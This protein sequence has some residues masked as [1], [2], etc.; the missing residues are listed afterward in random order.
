M[1]KY[2]IILLVLCST[3]LIVISCKSRCTRGEEKALNM[4]KDTKLVGVWRQLD[5]FPGQDEYMLLQADGIEKSGTTRD[6]LYYGS[7]WYTVDNYFYNYGCNKGQESISK[8]K[9]TVRNDTL[10]RISKNSKYGDLEII[11]VRVKE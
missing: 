3:A 11:Y 6:S 10:I 1:K 2:F 4:P 9:Y 5:F 8:N 7:I